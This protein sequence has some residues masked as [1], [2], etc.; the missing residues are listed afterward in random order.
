M[1]DI[2]INALATTATTSASDDFI[3]LDGTTNGTRKMNAATPAF[4]TSVTTPAVSGPSAT[5]LTLS[6]GSSGASLALGQGTNGSITLTPRG[7]G[8]A[9]IYGSATATQA[10]L[11]L[12]LLAPA[13]AE[14]Q[15]GA[16]SIQGYDADGTLRQFGSLNAVLVNTSGTVGYSAIN[17]HANDWSGKGSNNALRIYSLAAAFFATDY[18]YPGDGV[19]KVNGTLNM[20]GAI[21]SNGNYT[22]TSATPVVSLVSSSASSLSQF[23]AVST[24][25]RTMSLG[26]FG[27]SR[28]GT[29][30]GTSNAALAY[31]T[32]TTT[33]SNY[34]AT[35]AIG[36]QGRTAPIL[37][38]TNDTLAV[39]ISGSTQAVTFESNIVLNSSGTAGYIEGKEQSSS[40]AAP[41]SNG[42]RLYA[43][44]DG[45]G[46]TALYVRFATGAEQQIAIEP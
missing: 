8:L 34:P 37:F 17:L 46:K 10:R 3:A 18:T 26:V 39:T 5:D 24:T 20:N 2:R 16:V 30:F 29:T 22:G 42:W 25:N 28:A 23:Q 13:V 32:T 11:D 40:P 44:D 43:K 7:T 21:T 38:G 12:T 15:E 31:L 1:A 14:T 45:G 36:T 35:L 6:A 9:T 19:L 41:S 33:G 4:L 27:D